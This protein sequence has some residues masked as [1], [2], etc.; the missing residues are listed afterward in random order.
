MESS[1]DMFNFVILHIVNFLIGLLRFGY[2]SKV[3]ALI[4]LTYK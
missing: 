2:F 3:F 1:H 4:Y